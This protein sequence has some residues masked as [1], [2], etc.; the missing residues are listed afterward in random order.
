MTASAPGRRVL[1]AYFSRVGENYYNGGRRLLQVGNTEVVAQMIRDALGCDVFRIEAAQPYPREYDPTV[2]RNVREQDADA[3]P[4]IAGALPSLADYD[5]VILG[6]PI[7]NVRTPMIMTTFTEALDFTGTTVFP[8][9]T[10]AMSGL[11]RA[12][13]DYTASCRGAT[14]G[15]ALAIRGEQA[16]DSRPEVETWLRRISLIAS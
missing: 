6:S 4:P 8:L 9:T 1:L 10:H 7:W 3:R 13:E 11:G 16:A 12:V 2:A 5:T 14:L 15:E